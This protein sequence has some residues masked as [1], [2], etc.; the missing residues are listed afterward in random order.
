MN[1][2]TENLKWAVLKCVNYMQIALRCFK[3]RD[4]AS[5]KEARLV[6]ERKQYT[7][8]FKIA[9]KSVFVILDHCKCIKKKLLQL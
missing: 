2:H 8:K 3:K 7:F 5:T 4:K 1:R 9:T 6:R